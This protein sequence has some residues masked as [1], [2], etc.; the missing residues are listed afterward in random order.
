MDVPPENPVGRVARWAI[1]LA[2]YDFDIQHRK[3]SL[4]YVP[5]ALS[6]MFEDESEGLTR[7]TKRELER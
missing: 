3:G 4:H 6:R 5:D 7:G 1:E 2:Q